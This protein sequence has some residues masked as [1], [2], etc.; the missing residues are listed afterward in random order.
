M[1]LK[2]LVLKNFRNY[3]EE[4]LEFHQDTLVRGRNGA[5][6]S[7][8][9]EALCFL[10][11]GTDSRGT[12]NPTHLIQWGE[13]SCEVIAITDKATISRTLTQKGNGTLRVTRGD[14]STTYNATQFEQL[15]GS[16]DVFLA[17][18]LPGYFM[19]LPAER[20]HKVF[21]EV[22]PPVDRE[23]LLQQL[24]GVSF[25]DDESVRYNLS[26]RADLVATTVAQDRRQAEKD[27]AKAEGE[28]KALESIQPVPE[29]APCDAAG[30]LKNLSV[31]EKSWQRYR[32]NAALVAE[33]K[34]HND[35][36]DQH[37]RENANTK[38]QLEDEISE[39]VTVEI[40][41]AINVDADIKALEDRL[42]PLP[43]RPAYIQVTDKPTCPACAQ[44][45]GAK[46]REKVACDNEQHKKQYEALLAETE[47]HN[48]QIRQDI[49]KL[50]QQKSEN[51]QKIR[52][53]HA[54]RESY[55][56]V[57][58]D[59][60]RRIAKLVSREKRPEVA[61]L[62]EPSEQ[63]PTAAFKQQL[64]DQHQKYLGDRAHYEKSLEQQRGLDGKKQELREKI[65]RLTAAIERLEK[66]ERGLSELPTHELKARESMLAMQNCKFLVDQDIDVEY[67]GIPYRVQSEGFKFRTGIEVCCKFNSMMKRPH[68]ILVIDNADLMDENVLNMTTG[69]QVIGLYVDHAEEKSEKVV[70]RKWLK[71]EE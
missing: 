9:K 31:L 29:P 27:K 8:L 2:T 58:L 5:G 15:V 54:S 40:P 39:L 49:A 59:L 45:V 43:S 67:H 48:Q 4:T 34:A 32:E 3:K 26:R 64:V 66:L 1:A 50:K 17:A 60:E 22:L 14:V 42:K 23:V 25:V 30:T 55:N 20:K 71:G 68:G 13:D 37:N 10:F 33:I 56:R 18:M 12:R 70:V 52:A 7:G 36:V 46:H 57:K 38:K 41:E 69:S 65:A 63:L 28:L 11:G 47:T 21:Q 51:D 24:T 19:D 35:L 61:A 53:A 6:K 16:P 44:T 62:S